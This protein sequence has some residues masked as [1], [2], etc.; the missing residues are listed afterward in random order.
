MNRL[1]PEMG[2]AL[3]ECSFAGRTILVTGAA[4]GLGKAY[5]DY[6]A[7]LGATVV[8]NDLDDKV[9]FTF[10]STPP[11]QTGN[12]LTVSGSVSEPQ[13]AAA[14]VEC[15]LEA[16]GRID[17]LINNAGIGLQKN[18]EACDIGE[19]QRIMDVHYFGALNLASAV[20]PIMTAAKYGRILNV[21]SSTMYGFEGWSAYG[22]AKGAIFGLSRTLAVEGEPLGVHVNMLAPGAATQMLFANNPHPAIAKMMSETMPPEKVAP[23]AAWLVHPDC[24]ENGAAFTSAGGHITRMKLGVTEGVVTSGSSLE[25]VRDA[26]ADPRMNANFVEEKNVL[27]SLARRAEARKS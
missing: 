3:T 24:Q 13:T 4:G 5:V 19:F 6:L 1:E 20:W 10:S 12:V 25:G 15:A 2:R 8:A 18:F 27:A 9:R 21:V 14:I 23:T 17:G 11:G 16:T 26:I 7:S 22:A